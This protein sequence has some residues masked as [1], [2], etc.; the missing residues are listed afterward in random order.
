MIRKSVEKLLREFG[1]KMSGHSFPRIKIDGLI[2]YLENEDEKGEYDEQQSCRPKPRSW[3]R[4]ARRKGA[5]RR[6]GARQRR[7]SSPGP[8]THQCSAQNGI[9]LHLIDE[10]RLAYP[11]LTVHNQPGGTWLEIGSQVF[12][13]L[14]RRA[15]FLLYLHKDSRKWP[16]S[17]AFWDKDGRRE[18]IGPR[19]TNADGSVC[20]YHRPDESWRI[21]ASLVP[22]LDLH[23]Q[24]AAR[25]LHLEIFGWWPGPQI[26]TFPYERLTEFDDREECGCEFPLG[27]YPE[28]CKSKDLSVNFILAARDFR[29]KFGDRTVPPAVNDFANR[30]RT[31]PPLPPKQN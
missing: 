26:A 31:T 28:C 4:S 13:G 5:S 6:Q 2:H 19:H 14:D 30:R 1:T 15:Y 25:S 17:W 22:L 12:P 3:E 20:C 29:G 18:W 21:G 7:R 11:D 9:S 23:T 27:T 8:G 24:W 16:V 10:L